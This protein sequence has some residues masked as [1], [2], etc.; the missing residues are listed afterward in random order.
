MLRGEIVAFYHHYPLGG[1]TK[2]IR[3]IPY[4][5][6]ERNYLHQL[7]LLQPLVQRVKEEGKVYY[8]ITDLY[9]PIC[10]LIQGGKGK[11]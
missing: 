5:S 11:N 8:L 4:Y 7:T 1:K 10:R 6:T 2:R 9:H 3:S